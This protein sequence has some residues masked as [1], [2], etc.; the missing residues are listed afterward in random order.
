MNM[1]EKILIT[2]E[3]LLA[4]A[5]LA[6][7][8]VFNAGNAAGLAA[9][10]LA[11]VF[12][13]DIFGARTAVCAAWRNS[14]PVRVLL[15]AVLVVLMAAVVTAAVLSVRMFRAMRNDPGD[16]PGLIVVLGCQVRGE[17]P[18]R[19]LAHRL[20][21]AYEAMQAYPGARVVVSGGKGS[22]ELISE[23]ECMKRYL[24]EKGADASRIIMED[25]SATTF[26]NI[27]NTFAITDAEGLG[28]DI[29]I[30]TDGYHLYRASRIAA[31]CGAGEVRS[32]AADTEKRFIPTYWVREWIALIWGGVRGEFSL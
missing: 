29:T 11:V 18:S 20:D 25:K 8:P 3:L 9:C 4:G 31:A 19:M 32:I 13:A 16:P 14:L 10:A 26:E 6:A 30:V 2:A 1:T 27:R 12:T 15:M 17:R 22:D 21:A 28:R 23:A 5:M 24:V 7:F